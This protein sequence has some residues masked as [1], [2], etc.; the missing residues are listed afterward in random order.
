MNATDIIAAAAAYNADFPEALALIEGGTPM[1]HAVVEAQGQGWRIKVW[2]MAGVRAADG[3]GF[4]AAGDPA[5]A[6]WSVRSGRE[7]T[8]KACRRFAV[9][10]FGDEVPI[11]VTKR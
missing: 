9:R 2:A 5:F 1:I 10:T 4:I 3:S 8:A 7:D 11:E 6:Y